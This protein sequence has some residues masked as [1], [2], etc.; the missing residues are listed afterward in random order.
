MSLPNTINNNDNGPQPIASDL[1]NQTIPNVQDTPASQQPTVQPSATQ[2]GQ[3]VSNPATP[4]NQTQ[5]EVSHPAIKQA[6]ILHS[7]AETLAGG[8]RYRPVISADGTRSLQRIPMD[9]KDIGMAIALSAI[10]GALSGL[11]ARGPNASA[12]AAGLGFKTTSQMRQQ[13]DEEQETEAK[14]DFQRKQNSLV[15]KAGLTEANLRLYQNALQAGKMDEEFHKAFV[16]NYADQRDAMGTPSYEHI[17]EAE[18]KSGRYDVTKYLAL[19][20]GVVPRLD[21]NGSQVKDANGVPQWD[22]TYSLFDQTTQVPLHDAVNMDKAVRAGLP[23]FVK[24]DGSPMAFPDHATISANLAAITNH[25]LQMLDGLQSELNSIAKGASS[26]KNKFTA[27]DVYAAVKKDAS[28]LQA[29]QHAQRALSVIDT[30]D[31]KSVNAAFVAM[32]QDPHAA[33]YVGRIKQ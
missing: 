24:S 8:P 23:G 4:P 9:R 31:P 19:P 5:P 33:P 15:Q 12:Q 32:A 30:G 14:E 17:S 20:D 16:D 13:A 28:L 6:G 2:P 26:D 29:I 7:I 27:L 22:N 1:S 21:S 10:T 3:M 18:I 25:K 11:Q